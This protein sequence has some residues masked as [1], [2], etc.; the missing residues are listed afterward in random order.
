VRLGFISAEIGKPLCCVQ[1]EGRAERPQPIELGRRLWPAAVDYDSGRGPS[2]LIGN[3][4]GF[5][6]ATSVKRPVQG[7][8]TNGSDHAR[9]MPRS[10]RTLVGGEGRRRARDQDDSLPPLGNAL[11]EAGESRSG[12]R[13]TACERGGHAD[14]A[15]GNDVKKEGSE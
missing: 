15:N 8:D 9:A 3:C 6:L 10:A 11:R 12:A 4:K 13:W 5:D 14:A 7:K 2:L 1:L